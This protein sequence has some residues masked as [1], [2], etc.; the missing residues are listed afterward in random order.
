MAVPTHLFKVIIGENPDAEPCVGAFMVPNVPLYDADLD[1]LSVSISQLEQ[2]LGISLCRNL[3]TELKKKQTSSL[4]HT[5]FSKH[6]R[7]R[8]MLRYVTSLEDLSQ[9][10]RN[11]P[12]DLRADHDLINVYEE[13]KSRLEKQPTKQN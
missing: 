6:Y 4:P 1:Q 9:V 11:M 5:F 10:W 7:I 8:K 12:G 13:K 3:G 2:W